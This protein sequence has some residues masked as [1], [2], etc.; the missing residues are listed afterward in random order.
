MYSVTTFVNTE[1]LHNKLIPMHF[2]A[3]ED[4][5]SIH[6]DISLNEH[7]GAGML[8]VLPHLKS[9]CNKFLFSSTWTGI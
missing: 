1:T 5:L 4:H 7:Q 8:P 2:S 9:L 3:Q 6:P